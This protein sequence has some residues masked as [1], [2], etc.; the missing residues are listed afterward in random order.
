MSVTPQDRASLASPDPEMG[1]AE[2]LFAQLR[3]NS[4]DECRR[5]DTGHSLADHMQEQ[6]FDPD[7]VRRGATHLEAARMLDEL[8]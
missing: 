8:G 5:M 3:E 2:R 4:L 1:D 6:G 7:E